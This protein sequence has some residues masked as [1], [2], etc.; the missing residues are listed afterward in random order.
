[1]SVAAWAK[2]D[3]PQR[4]RDAESFL[5]YSQRLRPS[6]VSP[7]APLVATTTPHLK[8]PIIVCVRTDPLPQKH[9][10]IREFSERPVAQPQPDRPV[11]ARHF[12]EVKRRMKRIHSPTSVVPPGKIPNLL[13]QPTIKLLKLRGSP[14]L[15][16]SSLPLDHPVQRRC[17]PPPSHSSWQICRLLHRSSSAGPSR[18]PRTDA[19]SP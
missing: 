12:L 15:K 10:I 7:S 2:P 13:W 17:P 3:L 14:G 8:P 18:L 9:A 16:K 4:R 11:I 19:A 5:N 6:S 1:M